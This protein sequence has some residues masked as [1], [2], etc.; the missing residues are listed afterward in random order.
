MVCMCR[1]VALLLA[2]ALC[3]GC[4]APPEPPAAAEPEVEDALFEPPVRLSLA[5]GR[6]IDVG[7]AKGYA[8]PAVVDLDGQGRRDLVVGDF[9][10]Q[11]RRYRNL[12]ATG[13]P[14]YAEP[15]LLTAGG[16][17]ATVPMG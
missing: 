4:G 14:R 7:D 2:S 16:Q 5:D 8:C 12:A 9:S 1:T 13:R 11:F 3:F 10:G 15:E 6:P 17:P